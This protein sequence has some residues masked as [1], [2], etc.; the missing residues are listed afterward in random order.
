MRH[1]GWRRKSMYNIAFQNL[2]S[3]QKQL[4]QESKPKTSQMTTYSFRND[5]STAS[6]KDSELKLSL[7]KYLHVNAIVLLTQGGTNIRIEMLDLFRLILSSILS[8]KLQRNNT[9][10]LHLLLVPVLYGSKII[11]TIMNIVR[12][13]K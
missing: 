1:N 4:K 7:V 2:T 8:S 11:I 9:S 6:I 5:C 12:M 13:N 3:Q 10:C